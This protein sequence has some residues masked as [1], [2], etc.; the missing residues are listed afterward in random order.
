M[1]YGALIRTKDIFVM[2][3]LCLLPKI[4]QRVNSNQIIAKKRRRREALPA[5]STAKFTRRK[6]MRHE[7]IKKGNDET[8]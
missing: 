7:G 1:L 3:L 4:E 5:G 6:T 2:L 8:H